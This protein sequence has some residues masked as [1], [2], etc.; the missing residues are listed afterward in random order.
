MRF[1]LSDYEKN[2]KNKEAIVCPDP[3]GPDI[4]LTADHFQ[5]DQEFA[6]WKAVSDE[7]YRA[8]ERAE[9]RE[10]TN[11]VPISAL[12]EKM[13]AA[14]STEQMLIAKADTADALAKHREKLSALKNIL[15][16]T[17]LRRF[18]L[19]VIGGRPKIELAAQEGVSSSA[20]VKSIRQARRRIESSGIF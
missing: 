14:R 11:T 5:N 6:H 13:V 3:C 12:P 18:W 20:V 17:Q 7:D 8:R 4:L 15:T 1:Y 19:C 9:R 10:K 16:P 2:L